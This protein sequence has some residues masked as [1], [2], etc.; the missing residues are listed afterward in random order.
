MT[1]A[2]TRQAALVALLSLTACGSYFRPLPASNGTS[3]LGEY[4]LSMGL[5]GRDTNA[6]F[7]DAVEDLRD[8]DL[9]ERLS[10]SDP[11]ET[12]LA[13]LPMRNETSEHIDHALSRLLARLETFLSQQYEATVVSL[14]RQPTLWREHYVQRSAIDDRQGTARTGHQLGVEYV[15][16]GHVHGND[17][18][19]A[20]GRR[21]QYFLALEVLE[22]ATSTVV[23][24]LDATISKGLLR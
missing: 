15:M 8:S 20:R 9:I 12:T 6:I 16:T 10:A 11:A 17:E 18:L 5:D 4:T 2:F 24:R 13:I 14:D 22:V 19:A 21:V 1:S 7:Q 23:W 3:D